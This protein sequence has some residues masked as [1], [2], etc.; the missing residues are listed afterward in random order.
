MNEK[1]TTNMDTQAIKRVLLQFP[2]CLILFFDVG[3]I[4]LI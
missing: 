2:V 4:Y 3:D 1:I